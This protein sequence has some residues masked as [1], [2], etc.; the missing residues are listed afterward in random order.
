MDTIELYTNKYAALTKESLYQTLGELFVRAGFLKKEIEDLKIELTRARLENV[1]HEAKIHE[2]RN[3][4]KGL[5][6]NLM[7]YRSYSKL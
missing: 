3:E 4:I 1:G 7:E 5:Q 6:Q 2:L